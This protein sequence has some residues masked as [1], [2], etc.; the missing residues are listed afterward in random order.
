M[1]RSRHR[2]AYRLPNSAVLCTRETI[3]EQTHKEQIQTGDHFSLTGR[4]STELSCYNVS[5]STQVLYGVPALSESG[6]TRE[7]NAGHKDRGSLDG[8][9]RRPV[10]GGRFAPRL[11]TREPKFRLAEGLAPQTGLETSDRVVNRDVFAEAATRRGHPIRCPIGVR[12]RNGLL[13]ITVEQE[14]AECPIS[15]HRSRNRG[16]L[17]TK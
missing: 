9:S 15:V 14:S 6:R 1:S 3:P 2:E 8:P 10:F 16:C 7:P 12:Y 13:V 5:R 17:N 4:P 11:L